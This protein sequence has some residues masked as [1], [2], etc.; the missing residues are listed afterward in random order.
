MPAW[1]KGIESFSAAKSFGMGFILAGLN[2]KN[3]PLAI[4]ASIIITASG[5]GGVQQGVALAIF[6]VVASIT[7]IVPVFTYLLARE[8][9]EGILG[10]W[11]D[12]LTVNN[13]AVM[14]VLFLVFGVVLVGKG[15]QGL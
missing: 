11:K 4:A 7:V 15:I 9:A 13:K 6:V 5:V 1:M 14:A 3:L 2:P 10:G 12:W 8:R